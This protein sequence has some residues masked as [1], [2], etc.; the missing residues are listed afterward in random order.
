MKL[1]GTTTKLNQP[2]LHTDVLIV[3]LEQKVMLHEAGT[4]TNDVLDS[5]NCKKTLRYLEGNK[6]SKQQF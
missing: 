3:N 2:V 1:I 6:T 5:I 4:Q